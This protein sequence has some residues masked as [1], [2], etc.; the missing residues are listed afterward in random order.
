MYLEIEAIIVANKNMLISL[1]AGFISSLNLSY[2]NKDISFKH[3]HTL[4]RLHEFIIECDHKFTETTKNKLAKNEYGSDI[5]ESL[6]NFYVDV[7]ESLCFRRN[8]RPNDETVEAILQV[9]TE[10][11]IKNANR[12][13][14]INLVSRSLL[15]QIVFKNYN[16]IVIRHLTD[17]FDASSRLV[18]KHELF[19]SSQE[20]ALLFLNC[21]YDQYIHQTSSLSV[22]EQMQVSYKV[23]TDLLAEKP[24]LNGIFNEKRAMLKTFDVKYLL[25]LSKLKFVLSVLSRLS[26]EQTVFES[27][28]N[29]D[30]FAKFNSCIKET[31]ESTTSTIKL[32]HYLIKDMIRK[33]GSSSIKYVQTN[34]TLKW[35]TPTEIIGDEKNIVDKYV[36]GGEKYSA[37]KEA[38]TFCFHEKNHNALDEKLKNNA[39]DL[40][41]YLSVAFFQNITLLYRNVDSLTTKI[42]EIFDPILAKYYSEEQH[43]LKPLLNNSFN[44]MLNVSSAN[45]ANID[46][47]LLLV[48]LKF[49]I[50]YAKNEMI[51]PLRDLIANPTVMTE[52][53]FPTMPQDNLYDI[54]I[55]LAPTGRETTKF[56]GD[57]I[58]Y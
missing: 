41:P 36:L 26:Y 14:N 58:L 24:N 51:K 18:G 3:P 11:Q 50:L 54:K 37:C 9:I 28:Q 31:V 12:H 29:K 47:T 40:L 15:V 57:F 53:Y 48:Q 49:C 30:L 32:R 22:D 34:E 38:I 45:W 19:S 25:V 52:K 5:N 20:I 43:M 39:D 2:F 13:F 35:M 27:I 10:K 44:H 46:F 33:Y 7:V 42:A 6:N 17:W 4:V 23:L 55:A 1:F 8:Q 21:V 56:Y 16:E